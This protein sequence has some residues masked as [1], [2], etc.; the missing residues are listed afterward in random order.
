MVNIVLTSG[1]KPKDAI[2]CRI[3]RVL[4]NTRT[5]HNHQTNMCTHMHVRVFAYTQH[6]LSKHAH[7]R[8][9]TH[10]HT[11]RMPC[12]DCYLCFLW[13]CVQTRFVACPHFRCVDLCVCF[14][15]WLAPCPA[16]RLRSARPQ[17][18]LNV[19]AS[20]SVRDVAFLGVSASVIVISIDDDV[21]GV[22][23]SPNLTH[24]FTPNRTAGARPAPPPGPQSVSRARQ[25][26]PLPRAGRGALNELRPV[27]RFASLGSFFEKQCVLVYFS[28]A[29]GILWSSTVCSNVGLPQSEQIFIHH[30]I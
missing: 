28:Q 14:G 9:R 10:N 2:Y 18:T 15:Q 7:G 27:R 12:A 25:H 5:A 21:A 3:C 26:W 11:A 6:P 22:Q 13:C 20:T 17:V 1:T 8:A 30:V 4:R 23:W 29:F 19:T 16:D 24:V